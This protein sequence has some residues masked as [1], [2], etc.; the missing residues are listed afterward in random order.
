[1][2]KSSK[3]MKPR[4]FAVYTDP[5]HLKVYVKPSGKTLC[6]NV[7]KLECHSQMTVTLFLPNENLKCTNHVKV[8]KLYAVDYIILYVFPRLSISNFLK[9]LNKLCEMN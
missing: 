3:N 7:S 5:I 4:Y 9:L 8:H 2:L 6:L 1:M